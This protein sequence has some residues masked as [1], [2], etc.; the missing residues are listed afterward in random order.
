[1]NETQ[2]E[3]IY[4]ALRLIQRRSVDPNRN[5]TQHLAYQSAYDML[6]Y[7]IDEYAEGL[8]Q[9]D[10]VHLSCD[11]CR[12]CHSDDMSDVQLCNA[13]CDHE[14]FEFVGGERV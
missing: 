14:F 11:E 1:M 9:Y 13:C 12:K 7:A 10:D 4:E 5:L 6:R 3:L 8:A 2:I